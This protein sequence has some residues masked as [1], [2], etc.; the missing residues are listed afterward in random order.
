MPNRFERQY[1]RNQPLLNYDF[2]MPLVM[3]NTRTCWER[4]AYLKQ[5]V[6]CETMSQIAYF[7]QTANREGISQII[8]R[9]P[10]LLS[11]IKFG[12]S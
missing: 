12:A 1:F 8:L 11:L 2:E 3:S 4:I 5:Q 6:N 7:K 10:G 9:I